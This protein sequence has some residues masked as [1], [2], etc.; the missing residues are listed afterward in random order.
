MTDS[1]QTT[2]DAALGW[3]LRNQKEGGYWV[4]MVESNS[5]ME[6]EWLLA[7]HILGVKLPM[8]EGFIRT[9][10]HRQRPDGSWEVF[11]G[12]PDG[13]INA[14]VEVYAAL[15]AMGQ[16]RDRPELARARAF[17]LSK[18]GLKTVR[19]F[20]RY[21]LALIGVWPW[22]DTPNLPP[23]FIRFPL[24][25]PFNIYNFA[26]WARATMVPL[27]V[28]SARRPVFPLPGGDKLE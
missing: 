9:L 26:Q 28:L 14:T 24:W 2:L 7:S 1:L 16:S 22:T 3:L 11:P 4:G 5:C 20:T 21:W 13:D 18:G 15:L 23:E 27:A 8:Q 6:A 17:I 10:F 25:F 19:V 12:A